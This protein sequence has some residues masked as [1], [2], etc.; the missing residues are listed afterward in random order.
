MVNN[1]KLLLQLIIIVTTSSIKIILFSSRLPESCFMTLLSPIHMITNYLSLFSSLLLHLLV[2]Y[3]ILLLLFSHLTPTKPLLLFTPLW[4]HFLSLYYF[5][6]T[7]LPT[8]LF[9]PSSFSLLTL[10]PILSISKLFLKPSSKS[11]NTS[12]NLKLFLKYF[13]P[14]L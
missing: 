8:N 13:S 4:L 10:T 6:Q 7:L 3:H 14:L 12:V 9:P 11:S 5:P 1:V 2:S